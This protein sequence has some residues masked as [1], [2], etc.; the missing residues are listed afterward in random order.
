MLGLYGDFVVL[1]FGNINYLLIDFVCVC[2]WLNGLIVDY[3]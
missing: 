2:E 1:G 3:S